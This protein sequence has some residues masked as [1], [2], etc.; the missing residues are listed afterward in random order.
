M[1]QGRFKIK[2][3]AVGSSLA[4]TKLDLG[5]ARW[6]R[7]NVEWMNGKAKGLSDR[8]TFFIYDTDERGWRLK[9]NVRLCSLMFAY[10]RLIGEK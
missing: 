4:R 3:Q 10:V 9:A 2:A 8:N 1:D 5:R 7:R 6:M